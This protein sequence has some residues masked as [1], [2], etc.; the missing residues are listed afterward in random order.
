MT[1]LN[2]DAEPSA[3]APVRVQP[4]VRSTGGKCLF[5]GSRQ[6]Y[7]RIYTRN[8]G[9]DEVACDKHVKELERHSD[10][11]L[12]APGTL[13]LHL[14]STSRLQR[15]EC[16]EGDWK[17]ASAPNAKLTHPAGGERGNPNQ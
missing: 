16:N 6:C 9:Y 4:A 8:L 12:G 5:C 13:R 11:T 2:Q 14:S 3:I 10:E 7:T 1:K 15:G 17:I